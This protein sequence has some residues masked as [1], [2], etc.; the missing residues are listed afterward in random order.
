MPGKKTARFP[1]AVLPLCCGLCPLAQAVPF[2]IPE[3][4]LS[5]ALLRFSQQSG[6]NLIRDGS[7]NGLRSVAVKGDYS[8]S[9]ALRLLLSQSGLQFEP[10]A[11][12]MRLLRP[13]EPQEPQEGAQQ[14]PPLDIVGTQNPVFDKYK[15]PEIKYEVTRE[16]LDRLPYSRIGD[17]FNGVPGVASADSTNGAGL[18]INIRGLQGM[19]RIKTLV[20]G[21]L[22]SNSVYKGYP[23]NRENTYVDPDLI[24]GIDIKK[25]PDA[26]PLGAGVIGGIVNMRSLNASDIILDADKNYGIRLKGMYGNN[27]ARNQHEERQVNDTTGYSLNR[28]SGQG[29]K[30]VKRRRCD[31]SVQPPAC[32]DYF[33][34]TPTEIGGPI[35]TQNISGSLALA[36]RPLQGVELTAAYAERESGNYISGKRGKDSWKGY[37]N[38]EFLRDAEVYN[39]S[40]RSDNWLLKGKWQFLDDHS[41][42]LSHIKY[43]SQYG[44]YNY[45]MLR[46]FQDHLQNAQSAT[47]TAHYAWQPDNPWFDLRANLWKSHL[48]TEVPYDNSFLDQHITGDYHKSAVVNKSHGGELWNTTVFNG[49]PGEFS[50]KYGLSFSEEKADGNT[51]SPRIQDP[52]LMIVKGTRKIY[53]AFIQSQWQMTHWLAVNA[54]L[55]QTQGELTS[56]AKDQQGNPIPSNKRRALDPSYGLVLEPHKAVQLFAQWSHGSRMPTLRESVI[57]FGISGT[58]PNPD[59]KMEKAKNFEYGMNLLFDS[60]LQSGDSMGIKFS[61]FD[62]RYND[63]IMRIRRTLLGDVPPFSQY[64]QRTYKFGNIDKARYQGYELSAD[65]DSG[66]LFANFSL[67]HFDK[68]Q[69]CYARDLSQAWGNAT[70]NIVPSQCYDRPSEND[71]TGNY[72]PPRQEKNAGLGVR[73][74]DQKLVLG[75]QMKMATGPVQAPSLRGTY[76]ERPVWDNYEVYDLYGQ[77]KL[78]EN[79]ELGFSVENI[80]DRFYVPSYSSL[81]EATPAPGRTARGMFTFRF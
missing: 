4:E 47:Y 10:E 78:T 41:L 59:L 50:L 62:N 67:T 29:E 19:G 74:F 46:E 53:G 7:V 39:T 13:Q 71:Y 76:L 44:Y 57:D 80:T 66:L 81:T 26:G 12:G 32:S 73:L 43:R 34:K 58:A 60:V 72:I 54:A 75:A 18:Q 65:Y 27:I 49:L 25:G 23:G 52:D 21:T 3:Q 1:F 31:Y 8:E 16:Q 14:L 42:E 48:N 45:F 24:G 37:G 6:L 40:H 64:P 30:T 28:K 17:I 38:E 22:Q 15:S 61:K 35:P 70:P 51:E 9:E 68:I 36:L 69:F 77:F 11:S 5:S 20:D 63:Y 2:D 56:A 55:Q 79:L 33:E